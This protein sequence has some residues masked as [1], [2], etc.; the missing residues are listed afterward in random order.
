MRLT[1]SQLNPYLLLNP[2]QLAL[3]LIS[4]CSQLD[5]NFI[6][7]CFHNT[8]SKIKLKTHHAE[9]WYQSNYWKFSMLY[10]EC[11]IFRL[12]NFNVFWWPSKWDFNCFNSKVDKFYT[13]LTFI[14]QK[15]RR[16]RRSRRNLIHSAIRCHRKDIWVLQLNIADSKK[17]YI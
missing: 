13:G 12:Q 5:P 11:Y 15:N 16:V 10:S 7:A 1:W 9:A 8:I 4:N 14:V 17:I 2:S 6:S 3:D